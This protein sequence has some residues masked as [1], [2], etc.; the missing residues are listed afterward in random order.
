[1]AFR[2]GK[3]CSVLCASGSTPTPSP[4]AR[5]IVQA[6]VTVATAAGGDVSGPSNDG[7]L[8]L[9]LGDLS[10]LSFG[11]YGSL[12]DVLL[13]GARQRQGTAALS[14]EDVYPGSALASGQLKFKKKL[15]VGHKITLIDWDE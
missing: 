11:L 9:D 14:A 6:T 5:R 3:S 4:V 10:G 12:A 13:N 7:N 8:D 2:N 1:M 15:K